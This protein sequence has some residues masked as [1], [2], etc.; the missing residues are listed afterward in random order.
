MKEY[1]QDHIDELIAGYLVGQCENEQLDEL[2]GWLGESV[3]NQAYLA[4]V[5]KAWHYSVQGMA[6]ERFDAEAAFERFRMRARMIGSGSQSRAKKD[7]KLPTLRLMRY[8]AVACLLVAVCLMS[9][10]WSERS[11]TESFADITIDVPQG[12]NSSLR[13]PDGSLVTLN[14]GSSISYSQ[15]FGV[16]DRIVRVEGE[17]YFEVAH[18]VEKP[19]RVESDGM[20]V[21]V[22]GTV[23][24]LRNYAYD[25]H[26]TLSL[27]EG[28]VRV[29][30]ALDKENSLIL[31]PDQKVVMDK[32]T[33]RLV[34]SGT[35]AQQS[36][37]WKKGILVFDD[38]AL[39]D[40]VVELERTYDVDICLEDDS[41]SGLHFYGMFDKKT[42]SIADVLTSLSTT[43]KFCYEVID[44][45]HLIK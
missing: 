43:G 1:N 36:A 7:C 5:Q 13:L 10:Q 29:S 25:T 26:A 15:G 45:R 34:K 33:H 28:K 44:G 35:C 2:S 21:E 18:D 42:Q 24:N 3:E 38:I 22:L 9:Y 37:A 41:I 32:T 39:S 11:M 14:S 6:D 4:Q 17:V 27:I 30:D 8:V 12:S 19:F 20:E 16:H 23:F 31:A 40:I